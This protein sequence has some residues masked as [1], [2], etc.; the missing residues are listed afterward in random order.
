M[1]IQN[2][3]ASFDYFLSDEVTAGMKL[4]GTQVKDIKAGKT[5]L[6]ESHCFPGV[7][8][9]IWVK[10]AIGAETE[11]IKLLLNKREIQKLKEKVRVK[12]FTLV[13]VNIHTNKGYIKMK[14]ALGKGKKNYDKRNTIKE[15]DLSREM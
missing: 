10:L 1:L 15:R 11:T 12:G 2:R 6:A 5:S 3:R 9:E 4:S 13:P 8:N 7:G 14:I